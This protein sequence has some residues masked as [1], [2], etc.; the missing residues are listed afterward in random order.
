MI[1]RGTLDRAHLH[2]SRNRPGAGPSAVPT[3]GR[4]A[5]GARGGRWFGL[6]RRRYNDLYFGTFV[7]DVLG[8]VMRPRT[9]VAELVRR[10]F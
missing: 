3:S 1:S 9:V 6:Y 8:L 7:K 2:K 5:H 10:N 4:R